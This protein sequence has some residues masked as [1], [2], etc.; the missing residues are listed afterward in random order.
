MVAN[1]YR[2]EISVFRQMQRINLLPGFTARMRGHSYFVAE[3]D[4]T[5]NAL[6]ETYRIRVDYR[7]NKKPRTWVLTPQLVVRAQSKSIPH[8]FEQERLCLFLEKEWAADMYI[9]DTIIPWA[10][11]WLHYYELWHATGKWHGGGH[12]PSHDRSYRRVTQEHV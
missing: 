3:G 12:E 11:V 1:P 5:P 9:A 2:G 8:M 10:A 6:A 7:Q 4:I